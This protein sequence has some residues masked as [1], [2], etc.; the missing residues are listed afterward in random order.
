MPYFEL[1]RS[2]AIKNGFQV[3]SIDE[4]S[5]LLSNFK[6]AG[7]LA[8]H[9]GIPATASKEVFDLF[10]TESAHRQQL[11]TWEDNLLIDDTYNA[12]PESMKYAIHKLLAD[13]PHRSLAV[14]LGEMR[15]LGSHT[16]QAHQDLVKLVKSHPQIAHAFFYGVPYKKFVKSSVKCYYSASREDVFRAIKENHLHHYVLL[17]KGSRSLQMED[18]IS[19][20]TSP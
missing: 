17:F 6:L 9:L 5:E 18:I 4:P 2:I 13:H 12:N 8:Q 19:M 20:L 11:I 15:E 1:V 10:S 3:I 16:D 14:V 7:A